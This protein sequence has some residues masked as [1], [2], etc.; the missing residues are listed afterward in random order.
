MSGVLTRAFTAPPFCER[1]A[2]RYAGAKV[3]D[4][5]MRQRLCDCFEEVADALTYRVCWQVLTAQETAA[6]VHSAD[7]NKI[8]DGCA[9]VLLFAA[10]LGVEL[11][12]R[13]ARYGRISPTKALLLQAI[14]AERIEALCDAFCA[15]FAAE[16][17]V[18]LTRRFSPGYGDLALQTQK[19]VFAR[20]D[21]PRKIGLT[22]T[23][24]LQMSPS[25]S[26]TA[27]VGITNGEFQEK[28]NHCARCD[29]A[30][31]DYRRTV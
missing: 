23:D 12:R 27:F 17:N 1:E 13:I 10:T 4:E 11:D 3:A 25:K 5:E 19:D 9:Q 8:L 26:V 6:L 18:G 31:C 14:G 24:S 30:A 20:L 16:N 15:A 28:N 7:L 29:N 21:C 2:L 22:L